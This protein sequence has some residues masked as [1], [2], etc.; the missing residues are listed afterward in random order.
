MA[1]EEQKKKYSEYLSDHIKNVKL[2]F[3]WLLEN[4]PVV[5]EGYDADYIGNICLR[6]DSSKY[7]AEE[8]Y[9]YAEYFN[10]EKTQ[11]VKDAFDAA[12]LHHQHQNPH[13]LQHWLLQEDDGGVKAIEM[14]YEYCIEM[15]ADWWSFSWKSDDLYEIFNWYKDHKSRIILHPNTEAVI[16]DIL[17]KLR[18]KLDEVHARGKE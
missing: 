8:F 5:F 6:H 14:P 10:G 12:W 18:L 17:E 4:L 13:H 15:I 11:E 3:E 7:D 1:T 16:E 9:A 2:G